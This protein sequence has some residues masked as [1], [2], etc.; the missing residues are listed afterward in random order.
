MAQ[1]RLISKLKSSGFSLIKFWDCRWAPLCWGIALVLFACIIP[2]V[3]SQILVPHLCGFLL[4]RLNSFIECTIFIYITLIY[5]MKDIICSI[6]WYI[7]FS[8]KLLLLLF[9]FICLSCF[10]FRL[11][12]NCWMF[13]QMAF[14]SI[15]IVVLCLANSFSI[16]AHSCDVYIRGQL[17]GVSSFF[18]TRDQT[19]VIKVV[20]WESSS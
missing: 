12:E 10:L 17:R 18:L 1:P 7:I 5:P 8:S 9:Y 15:F 16:C 4:G 19:H 13:L 20:L 6:Y 3:L 11:S 2:S 14:Y